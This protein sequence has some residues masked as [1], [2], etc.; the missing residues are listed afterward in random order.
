MFTT[1]E[2]CRSCRSLKRNTHTHS[3][4][5]EW[6]AAFEITRPGAR[7]DDA[8]VLVLGALGVSRGFQRFQAWSRRRSG[9]F[10]REAPQN[11]LSQDKELVAVPSSKSSLEMS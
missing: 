1:A 3:I 7:A 8:R 2:P 10:L 9:I 11:H 5:Q 6:M 4:S